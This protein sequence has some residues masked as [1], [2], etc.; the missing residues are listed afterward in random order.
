MEDIEIR[1]R[2]S[3]TGI[4]TCKTFQAYSLTEAIEMAR[5][6]NGFSGIVVSAKYADEETL[7]NTL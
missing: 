7:I 3:K 2:Q 1:F 5:R 6:E 4:I